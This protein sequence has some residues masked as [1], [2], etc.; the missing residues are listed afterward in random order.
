[1]EQESE[2]VSALAQADV[3]D[4]RQLV[5]RRPEEDGGRYEAAS[6]VPGEEPDLERAQRLE[7]RVSA[8]VTFGSGMRTAIRPI[9]SHWSS[10]G[11]PAVTGRT[12]VSLARAEG[13]RES[14]VSR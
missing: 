4:R 3:L 11:L 9:Q 12:P 7:Y 6:R 5:E 8:A 13:Q 10:S 1:V 14:G 2:R